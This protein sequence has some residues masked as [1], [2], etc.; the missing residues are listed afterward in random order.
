MRRMNIIAAPLVLAAGLFSCSGASS[1]EAE[2]SVAP[3]EKAPLKAVVS[4][5]AKSVEVTMATTGGKE[6]TIV[7]APCG[8]NQLP[9]LSVLKLGQR[10]ITSYSD[11]VGPYGMFTA[12]NPTYTGFTGGWHSHTNSTYGKPTAQNLRFSVSFDGTPLEDGGTFTGKEVSVTVLNGINSNDT[13]GERYGREVLREEVTYT[14]RDG[15]MYV[16]VVS[17]PL[18]PIEIF[19]YYGMQIC[20]FCDVFT[21]RGTDGKDYVMDTSEDYG[22][23][24]HCY[25]IY[26][27]RDGCSV[28]AHLDTEGLGD[29]ALSDP[30][31]YA[32]CRYYGP[33]NGK[34]YYSLINRGTLYEKGESLSWSGYYEFNY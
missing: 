27:T 1:G 11:W 18:E 15:L 14:F 16:S 24:V 23:P 30:E 6:H 2:K 10:E 7:L 17:T 33:G 4:L 31:G 20:G 3:P 28:R 32:F 13:K 21:F 12:G 26:G 19:Q 9:A 22:C 25:D 29:Q 5:A 8:V 34:A